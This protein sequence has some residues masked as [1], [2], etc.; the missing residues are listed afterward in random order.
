MINRQRWGVAFFF[1]SEKPNFR[2]LANPVRIFEPKFFISVFSSRALILQSGQ[3]RDDPPGF[4][5]LRYLIFLKQGCFEKVDV[6]KKKTERKNKEIKSWLKSSSCSARE[7][8]EIWFT[9][10]L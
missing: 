2:F 5:I 6:K 7:M 8:N 1:V 3:K 10:L 9:K 4:S